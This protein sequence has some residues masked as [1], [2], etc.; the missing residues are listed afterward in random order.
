M[1]NCKMCNKETKNILFCSRKCSNSFQALHKPPRKGTGKGTPICKECKKN[2]VP[3][4]GHKLCTNCTSVRFIFS[5][6]PTVRELREYYKDS[7]HSTGMQSYIRSNARSTYSQKVLPYCVNCDYT[8]HAEVCH[9]K[10]IHDFTDDSRLS[11]INSEANLVY[12]CPNCHWEFDNGLISI[13]K[14]V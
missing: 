14:N 3:S 2:Q 12:L 4:Y 10:P 13:S 6:D 7:K 11:E 1:R 5:S 9:I 8:Y